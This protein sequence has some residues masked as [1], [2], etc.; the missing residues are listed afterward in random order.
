[1]CD[2]TPQQHSVSHTSSCSWSRIPNFIAPLQ[3]MGLRAVGKVRFAR[4]AAR[5]RRWCEDSDVEYLRKLGSVKAVVFDLRGNHSGSTR[6]RLVEALMDRPYRYWTESTPATIGV[7]Q[8]ENGAGARS[9]LTWTSSYQNPSKTALKYG[10]GISL[11]TR[12]E[13]FPDGSAF[14]GPESP[15]T[16]R[17]TPPAEDLRAGKDLVLADAL[18]MV[19]ANIRSPER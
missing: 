18:A 3:A 4:G 8:V 17:C 15:R 13:Y 9:D 5:S 11:N 6:E 1:M 14:E 2:F 16:W 10:M 19:R 7:L 12:R